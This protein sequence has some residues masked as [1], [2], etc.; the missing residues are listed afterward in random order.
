[1]KEVWLDR[2]KFSKILEDLL[3]FQQNLDLKKVVQVETNG[4]F[5]LAVE[6]SPYSGAKKCH[7]TYEDIM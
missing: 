4:V 2:R 5:T 7:K 6:L 3:N 1:M